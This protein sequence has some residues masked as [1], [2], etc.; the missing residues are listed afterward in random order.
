M[1]DDFESWRTG[2]IAIDVTFDTRIQDDLVKAE[3]ISG[4]LTVLI[5]GIV[6]EPSSQHFFRSALRC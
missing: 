6:L 1:D 4:P 3:L 5:L 2:E